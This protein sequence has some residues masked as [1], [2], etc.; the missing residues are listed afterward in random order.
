[1]RIH[2]PDHDL[3][4]PASNDHSYGENSDELAGGA[5]QVNYIRSVWRDQSGAGR[6]IDAI[7]QRHRRTNATIRDRAPRQI[8]ERAPSLNRHSHSEKSV[9][10]VK[11]RSPEFRE[12]AGTPGYDKEAAE[13]SRLE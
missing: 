1:M 9:S 5:D 12:C 3:P 6:V 10:S 8:T 13:Q 11:R 4:L 7:P 2:G